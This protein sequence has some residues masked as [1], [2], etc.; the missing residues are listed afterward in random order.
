MKNH[1]LVTVLL[2]VFIPFVLMAHPPK[3]F[4][5]KYD[6][7]T[8]MLNICIPHSVKNVTKHYIE[9]ITISVNGDEIKVLEYKSQSSEASHD[10]EIEL[11]ELKNGDKVKVKAKCNKMGA[12]TTII[13]IL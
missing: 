11:P 2:L 10:V 4:N 6:K 9:S 12:K 3:K 1:K 13:K 7:E 5:V 8:K